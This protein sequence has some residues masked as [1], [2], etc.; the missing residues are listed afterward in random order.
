MGFNIYLFCFFFQYIM[1]GLRVDFAYLT[2]ID[3]GEANCWTN[4]LYSKGS[5]NDTEISDTL[6]LNFLTEKLKPDV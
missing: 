5:I 6:A 1:C 4:V 3:Y 2:V